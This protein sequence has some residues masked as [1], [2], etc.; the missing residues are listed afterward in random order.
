M[1]CPASLKEDRGKT[2][3]GA[4]I[5]EGI[6]EFFKEEDAVFEG[7]MFDEKTHFDGPL[8]EGFVVVHTDTAVDLI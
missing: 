4:F 2:S 1:V 8:L 6:R 3:S 7:A 5:A